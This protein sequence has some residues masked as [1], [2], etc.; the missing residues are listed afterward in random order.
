MCVACIPSHTHQEAMVRPP[1]TPSRRWPLPIHGPRPGRSPASPCGAA[2]HVHLRPGELASSGRGAGRG[3]LGAGHVV[4][5]LGAAPLPGRRSTFVMQ[6]GVVATDMNSY[7]EHQAGEMP[8]R[9]CGVCS[10]CAY[11]PPLIIVVPVPLRCSI[12]ALSQWLR[13]THTTWPCPI[14][15]AAPSTACLS[16]LGQDRR[17]VGQLLGM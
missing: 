10:S 12:T 5:M 15:P 1:A 4:H 6:R 2:A 13:R 9:V 17:D 11:R 3:A 7:C 8:S 14:V 16:I